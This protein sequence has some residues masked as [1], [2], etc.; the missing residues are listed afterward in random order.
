MYE[1]LEQELIGIA[2]ALSEAKATKSTDAGYGRLDIAATPL[3][4][5]CLA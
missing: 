4:L 2:P 5:S 3:L 1:W